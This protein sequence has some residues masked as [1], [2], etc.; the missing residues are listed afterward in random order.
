[1][2]I[3]EAIYFILIFQL[4]NSNGCDELDI[5]QPPSQCPE[6]QKMQPGMSKADIHKVRNQWLE[7]EQRR[8]EMHSLRCDA[9][10]KLSMADHVSKSS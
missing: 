9:L 3:P 2:N 7:Y 5:P 10:Y 4:F 8:N 1:M 6:P